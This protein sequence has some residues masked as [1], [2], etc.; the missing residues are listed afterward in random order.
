MIFLKMTNIKGS[1]N[2]SKTK[3]SV[4]LIKAAESFKCLDIQDMLS[5]TDPVILTDLL[6][7]QLRQCILANTITSK[8]PCKNRIIKPWITIGVLRCIRNRND[9]QK[10]LKFDPNNEILKITYRRYRNHCN[11]LIKKLKR[12]YDTE[13]LLKNKNNPRLLWKSIN[14]I[15]HRKVNKSQNKELLNS[16]STP[17]E[18]VDF[19]NYYF[20]NIGKTLANNILQRPSNRNLLPNSSASSQQ[21]SSFVLLETDSEEVYN[22]LMGLKSNSAAGWDGIGTNF[23]KL[24]GKEVS[25][26]VAH[27]VNLCMGQGIFPTALKHAIVTPI[28]KGG[29]RDEASNYRPISVLPVLS[30]ILEKI[31]NCRLISFLNKY[32]LISDCQ[33]GFRRGISTEDAIIAL[34]SYISEIV[35]KN[36]KC[37]TV[38]LD[39]Q[40]A[41]DTV[42]VPIL[43]HRLESLGIR[44]TPL[45]LLTNY[46]CDRRQSVKVG[47]YKSESADITYGVPQGSVLGPTLFLIYIN[48]LCNLKVPN[49]KLISYADDT[50]I[51]FS[52]STWDEVHNFAQSGLAQVACWLDNNLLTLN[53]SKTNYICF[54]NYNSSQPN[55]DYKIKIHEC[56]DLTNKNCSCYSIDKISQTKYLGVMVDQRLTWYSHIDLLTGRIRKLSWMFKTLRHVAD[57]VL[58]KQIYISLGQ[59]ILNYCIPIWGGSA[60]TRFLELERAHRSLLKVIYFK[61][62]RFP[63]VSLYSQ[64]GLLSVRKLYVLHAILKL[65]KKLPYNSTTQNKKRRIQNVAPVAQIKTVYARRQFTFQSARIY[66]KLNKIL[67]FH[68]TTTHSCKYRL[69]NWLLGKDYDEIENLLL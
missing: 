22:I 1:I 19:V 69:Q 51:V 5:C 38:F 24:I 10:K 53:A 42:S 62:Y 47:D 46:L 8:I 4:I 28:H 17:K 43:I 9:M 39:L 56:K 30:K 66:N 13:Q 45:A 52:G 14:E 48:N 21:A 6:I 63:T 12:N 32:K 65:H 3:T 55:S 25:H 23:L 7:N 58:L 15:T 57:A 59:S 37:I 18:S 68:P 11:A 64:C 20:A 44:G 34:T 26:I 49:A 2:T 16:K 60:K 29:D 50:A 67:N 41:F 40:K 61:P 36:K 27:L 35:D 54:T 31:I 33:F